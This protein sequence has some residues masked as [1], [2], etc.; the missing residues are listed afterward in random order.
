MRRFSVVAIAAIVAALV[1]Y[2]GYWFYMA[3][4]LR[5]GTLRWAE[6]ARAGGRSLAWEEMAVDGY[7]LAFRISLR[8]AVLGG[9]QP[10]PYEV[11]VATLIG[12]ARPWDLQRWRLTAPGGFKSVMPGGPETVTVDGLDGSLVLGKGTV[13]DLVGHGVSTAGLVSG[14]RADR[15]A[16]RL[17]LPEHPP[18]QHG[19]TAVATTIE[20]DQATLPAAVPPFGSTIETLSLD[21]AFKGAVPSGPL[22]QA[23]E[24]WRADGGTIE[25][26]QGTL[27]W[28]ALSLTANGTV[29]LDEALQPL[30]AFTATI[31][32]H[33]AI[34]DAAVANGGLKAANA[35]A[36]K[37]VLG[38]L[39]KPGPDGKKRL[40]VP[41]SIQNER[42]YLGPA[43]IAVLPPITWK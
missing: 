17:T 11:A 12:K 19:D 22:H 28:G 36:V 27:R 39:A 16:V 38:L 14:L 6:A 24:A 30:A 35:N 43:Q 13:V 18:Q 8:N 34:V 21:G 1:A 41:V 3:S 10:L 4:E 26:Q 5:T 42:L 32:N 33:N 23:L 29:A 7:P 31:E 20:L 15:I 25:L 40:T 9:A 37:L 2:T